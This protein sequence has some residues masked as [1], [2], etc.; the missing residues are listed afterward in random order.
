MCLDWILEKIMNAKFAF[1]YSPLRIHTTVN[2]G[3]QN[4]L[5]LEIIILPS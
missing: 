3:D 2:K 4:L 1:E 5:G